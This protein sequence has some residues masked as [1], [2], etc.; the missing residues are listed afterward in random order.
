M[1]KNVANYNQ[2]TRVKT[3]NLWIN[4]DA[5]KKSEE[6]LEVMMEISKTNIHEENWIRR[7]QAEN[8][9]YASKF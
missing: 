1:S 5:T 7:T 2:R 4:T 6:M 8:Y 3:L 9:L